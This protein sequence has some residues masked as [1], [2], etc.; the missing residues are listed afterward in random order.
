M[1]ILQGIGGMM[2]ILGASSM[3]SE[4]IVIPAV[5]TLVGILIFG[6]CGRYEMD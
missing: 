1:K 2:F 5:M 4:S 3:D 6:L